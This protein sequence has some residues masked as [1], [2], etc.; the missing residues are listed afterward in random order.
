MFISGMQI[1]NTHTDIIML[2]TIKGA[3]A[4]RIYSAVN[5][6]A[7]LITFVLFAVNAPL[8]PVIS[9]LYASRYEATAT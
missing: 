2:G 7:V 1:I 5:R 9:S 8:A 3:E 4:A 6:G